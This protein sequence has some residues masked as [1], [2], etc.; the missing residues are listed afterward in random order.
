MFYER[1]AMIRAGF[2]IVPGSRVQMVRL[3]LI[4]TYTWQED[5]A[6][7]LKVPG[8]MGNVNLAQKQHG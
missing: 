6:K 3:F 1:S 4:S 2:T 8:A 5:V 7:I